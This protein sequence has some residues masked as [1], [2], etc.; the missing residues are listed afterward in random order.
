MSSK[1]ALKRVSKFVN[2][3]CE[4][5]VRFGESVRASAE[6]DTSLMFSDDASSSVY[7]NH[8]G[9]MLAN[10]QRCS[11]AGQPVRLARETRQLVGLLLCENQVLLRLDNDQNNQ[12]TN[13]HGRYSTKVKVGMP[14]ICDCTLAL[15][16]NARYSLNLM[17]GARDALLIGIIKVKVD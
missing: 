10:Y 17:C 14:E 13:L 2:D 4:L 16:S 12:V 9:A 5:I 11:L 15:T 8:K 7:S 3:Y 6:V 1:N